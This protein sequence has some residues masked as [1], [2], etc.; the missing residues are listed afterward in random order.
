MDRTRLYRD[1]AK[2]TNGDIYIGVIGPVRSGKSTFVKRFSELLMLPNMENEFERARVLD[3]LPQSG[4]GRSIMTTQ[5]KFVPGEAVEINLGDAVVCKL[6]MV[7]CVG[8][9]IPDAV[10][11]M[12]DGRDRMVT[13]PWFDYDIPF[14]EAAT[15]GTQKVIYEH[16]TIGIV[17]T[18][19]G[20]I[21]DLPRENY[22]EAEAKA[23]CDVQTTG[24]PYVIIVNSAD[25][26]GDAAGKTSDE[27]FETYGVRPIV[28]DVLHLSE[29]ALT[30]L[31]HEILLAFP[32]RLLNVR[33][34]NYLCALSK[35]NRLLESVLKPLKESLHRVRNMRDCKFVV[36]ALSE[37]EHFHP[38]R[39]DLLQPGD[40]TA[41]ISIQPEDDVFYSVLS[42]ACGCDITDDY[43]L[44][45][46]MREFVKAKKE[47][48]RI[49]N[50]LFKAQQTGYGIVPPDTAEME[51]MEPEIIRQGSKFGVKLRA[52]ASG[53]HIIRIDTDCEVNPLVGS[54]QQSEALVQY[55]T[56]TFANDPAAIWETN[57]F[58]KSLYEWVVEGMQ[59]RVN[60]MSEQVQ[61][62][63]QTAMQRIVNSDCNGL[64]CIMI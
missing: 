44:L 53:L 25:P 18:T 60:G 10:G 42:E 35:E 9:L 13:T 56:E 3:E 62:R 45:Q 22:R 27:I 63:M 33:L 23:I 14:S 29:R 11:T 21:M 52:K 37:I 20:T 8:Y 16:A 40:G 2:R 49:E 19:D 50:A 6:R 5:P 48:D 57:L 17:M 34:P 47:Y 4:A 46:S 36:E 43:S 15:I 1:I 7:D 38:A 31:L 54:E 64:I 28:L 32:M 26:T 24:K 41:V 58:G 55:L 12:E 59:G 30:E 61:Q 39:M 51:L